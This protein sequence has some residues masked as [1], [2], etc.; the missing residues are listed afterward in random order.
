MFGQLAAATATR[1]P[2]DTWIEQQ[3][4]SM[5]ET[6]NEIRGGWQHACMQMMMMY[7][8]GYSRFARE[9]AVVAEARRPPH[10]Q[11]FAVRADGPGA[12]YCQSLR[13]TRISC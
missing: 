13:Q 12:L 10:R 11:H 3:G 1:M 9:S 4:H 6:M 5:D 2:T 8:C 7:V